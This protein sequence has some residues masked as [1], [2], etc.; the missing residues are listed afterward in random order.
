MTA[1][2]KAAARRIARRVF[3]PVLGDILVAALLSWAGI[4]Y[5]GTRLI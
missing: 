3:E 1:I 5:L 2:A 4:I